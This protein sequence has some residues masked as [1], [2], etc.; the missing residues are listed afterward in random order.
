MYKHGFIKVVSIFYVMVMPLFASDGTFVSTSLV[1]ILGGAFV[2][3]VFLTFT[4]CVLPM[5]PILSGVIAGEGKALT[6]AKGLQLSLAYVFGTA[7][8]Y[9]AMGALAGATGEQLQSYFQNVWVIGIMSLIFVLMALGMFGWF[10]IQLPAVLQTRLDG[11]TRRLKGGKV[12]AVFLL[13]LISALVLGAC[14]SPVLISFLSVAIA[15]SDPLLGAET[16]FALALGMGVPLLIVGV[17]AGYL[18]PKAGAW[19]DGVKHFFGVLLLGVAIALFSELQLFSPLYLWGVFFV[20]I[21]V[22]LG[23]ADGLSLPLHAVEKFKIMIAVLL[24]I[25]GAI[26]LVGA[27]KGNYD[28]IAPLKNVQ[29]V[30]VSAT[31]TDLQQVEQLPFEAVKNISEYEAAKAAARQEQKPMIIFFHA[32]HC[33]VCKELENTTL[34]DP[35]VRNILKERYVGLMVDVTDKS[36]AGANALRKK[37]KVF[38]PPAFVFIDT[39]GIVLDD[40]IIYGYQTAQELFDLL[41][42]NAE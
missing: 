3:G 37:L 20:G 22:Y 29:A 39:E 42:I 7:V 10:T 13:G 36:D 24:L 34:K 12:F 35:N 8:T 19:M 41:D 14:V 1:G 16:M 31:N 26:T 32:K 6:K 38:G 15:T 11:S 4:P 25:W 23:A 17:G 21:A 9:A 18:L 2:A 5:I 30:T 40:D 28:V 27:A 33:K